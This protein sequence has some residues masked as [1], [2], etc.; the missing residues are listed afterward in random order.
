MHADGLGAADKIEA[1]GVLVAGTAIELEPQDVGRNL[2]SAFDGH[3][4]HETQHVGHPRTLRRGCEMLI[5][6]G[7]YDRG[8]SHGRNPDRR[9]VAPAE[10]FDVDR[11]QDGGHAIARHE[12]DRVERGPVARDA[13]IGTSAA[14]HVLEG[15]ARHVPAGTLA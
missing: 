9:R 2:G 8:A 7:P 12:L 6:A 5:G 14:V 1:D 11:R 15:E 4:T 13:A 3:S 10:Q